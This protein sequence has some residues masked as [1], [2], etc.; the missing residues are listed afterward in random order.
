MINLVVIL[1]TISCM[2]SSQRFSNDLIGCTSNTS[3]LSTLLSNGN[4]SDFSVYIKAVEKWKSYKDCGDVNCI[5]ESLLSNTKDR[6]RKT[7][8]AQQLISF[9]D[10]IS[11]FSKTPSK[12]LLLMRNVYNKMD[13]CHTRL[14]DSQF[15]PIIM[16][17]L[18]Q[19]SIHYEPSKQA[20]FKK[21][22]INFTFEDFYIPMNKAFEQKNYQAITVLFLLLTSVDHDMATDYV[23]AIQQIPRAYSTQWETIFEIEWKSLINLIKQQ[24]ITRQ[25][26]NPTWNVDQRNGMIEIKKIISR[27]MKK[28][29]PQ[30]R[31]AK[32]K[33]ARIRK[34][35][36]LEISANIL[37]Y[38]E[39]RSEHH[40][41]LNAI[42]TMDDMILVFFHA[43]SIFFEAKFN[44]PIVELDLNEW[45]LNEIP[46]LLRWVFF[47]G[48]QS[49]VLSTANGIS[50]V[51]S[52]SSIV[53]VIKSEFMSW[54]I[55]IDY[56]T[57]K[58]GKDTHLI[59]PDN[60]LEICRTASPAIK[61]Y[62]NQSTHT[63]PAIIKVYSDQSTHTHAPMARLVHVSLPR[64][65]YA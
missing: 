29:E 47:S 8:T 60:V 4:P 51:C 45:E 16:A 5:I 10:P 58:N 33:K 25:D 52:T 54:S 18:L 14:N 7:T 44:L 65:F 53:D 40:L 62:S 28:I 6:I 61:V 31:F 50:I 15:D 42:D 38:Q 22:F 24:I 39:H 63:P 9:F 32:H 12:F 21:R 48:L 46:F 41:I 64:K 49:L 35:H 43:F 30:L 55:N 27:R 2:H 3:Q 57:I 19:Q 36:K 26:R 23:Q 20:S 56:T 13:L 1:F 34:L 59:V 37:L 17:Q 11:K